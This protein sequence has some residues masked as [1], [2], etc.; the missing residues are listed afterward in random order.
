MRSS[1]MRT[2]LLLVLAGGVALPALAQK[3]F[4]TP[5]QA[6]EALI[7]AAESFD[8]PAL[9]EILGPDGVDLV[10][11]AGKTLALPATTLQLEVRR[12]GYQTFTTS[13]TP[14]AGVPRIV[15]YRLQ[16]PEQVQA[17]R[18]PAVSKT[19]TGIELR[20]MPTGRFEMG[21]TRRDAGSRANESRRAVTLQRRFYLGT[22]EITN[23]DYLKF[24]PEHLSGIV[25][26]RSLDQD[27][28]PVVN[29][30]WYEAA[31]YC[32]WAGCR[33]PNDNEWERAARGE[34]GREYPWGKEEPDERRANYG[35]YLRK[36][37]GH[38]TP[39]GLYPMGATPEGLED[40]AGN[41]WEWTADWYDSGREQR[42]LRGGSWFGLPVNLRAASRNW[43]PPDFRIDY[44]GFRCV[45]EVFP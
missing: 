39:V 14:Q 6:S 5:E 15:E 38:P 24:R 26:D 22:R 25:K 29:V 10:V 13:V 18:F 35:V 19:G 30:S 42:S 43:N 4:D 7:A 17:E 45:R 16:T 23:A 9:K 44:I 20:L 2:L 11:P 40:M 33:L 27:T 41:V 32:A 3:K 1:W 28:H 31:A 36:G 21:S 34:E 12:E 37:P 8:L